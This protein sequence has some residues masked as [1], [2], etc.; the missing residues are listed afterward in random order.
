MEYRQSNLLNFS[1][2][3]F[4]SQYLFPNSIIAGGC[5]KN[6]FNHEKSKTL[7][8]FFMMANLTL[9]QLILLNPTQDMLMF[10]PQIRSPV[11]KIIFMILN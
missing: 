5:F 1:Q 10:T 7:I 8:Y 3:T 9:K 11:I 6:I 4:L 2:L